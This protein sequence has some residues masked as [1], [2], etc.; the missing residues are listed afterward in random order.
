[1]AAR[2]RCGKGH[3]DVTNGG[4]IRKEKGVGG[5][6]GKGCIPKG[7]YKAF[8]TRADG[9]R[10]PE[11]RDPVWMGMGWRRRKLEPT[12]GGGEFE[13]NALA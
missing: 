12:G 3:S 13:T 10:G 11:R 1:M 2:D 7:P 8:R 6:G 5:C 4:A 9:G